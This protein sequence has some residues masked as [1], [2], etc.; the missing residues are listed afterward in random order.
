MFL[1]FFVEL[2]IAGSQAADGAGFSVIRVGSKSK[3]LS[4]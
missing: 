3:F 1:L 4:F 2:L